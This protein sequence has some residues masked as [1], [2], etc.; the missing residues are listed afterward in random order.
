MFGFNMLMR[1]LVDYFE[2]SISQTKVV[3]TCKK[4][5]RNKVEVS[6]PS[7]PHLKENRS[8]TLEAP[9]NIAQHDLEWLP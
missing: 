7:T 4:S 2:L 6:N 8:S 9:Y 1:L 3:P 5:W